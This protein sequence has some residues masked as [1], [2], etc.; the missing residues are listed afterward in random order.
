MPAGLFLNYL[1]LTRE[2]A[3]LYESQNYALQT[4]HRSVVVDR[5]HNVRERWTVYD[6]NSAYKRSL[7]WA[8]STTRQSGYRLQSYTTIQLQNK[9]IMLCGVTYASAGM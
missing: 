1:L 9:N 2:M 3:V 4:Y 6:A 7:S 5:V 8:Q